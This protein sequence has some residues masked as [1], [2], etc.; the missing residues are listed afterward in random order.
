MGGDTRMTTTLY[1]LSPRQWER[2]IMSID[3]DCLSLAQKCY[4]V[5][6]VL[7]I[8]A[9]KKYAETY[10]E[11]VLVYDGYVAS[12]FGASKSSVKRA[13]KEIEHLKLFSVVSQRVNNGDTTHTQNYFIASE[14][15]LNGIIDE[16][17]PHRNKG[18]QQKHYVCADCGS[19]NTG[20]MTI[21][22]VTKRHVCF[23]CGSVHEKTKEKVK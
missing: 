12:F 21:T 2:K 16:L 22:R 23:D 1:D 7:A 4:I 20:T 15:L 5:A 13:R 8:E 10:Q 3:N 18:N 9:N 17:E 6:L 14:N 19:E 11:H